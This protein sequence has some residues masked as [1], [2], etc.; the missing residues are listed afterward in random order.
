MED[1]NTLEITEEKL[2][3]AIKQQFG[4]NKDFSITD[5][6]DGS[7]LIN[8]NDTKRSYYIESTGNIIDESNMIK[9]GTAEE[10]KA[11]RDDVNKGNTYEGK[12]VYLTNDIILDINEEW[13]PIGLYPSISNGVT[14]S[15]NNKPFK[16]IF[17][18]KGFEIDGIYINTTERGQGLFGF[19]EGATIKNLGIGESCNISGGTA[20]GGVAGYI[21]N[22]SRILNSYNKGNI[23][24]N[25]YVGG[26]SGYQ[27]LECKIDHCYNEGNVTSKG[28]HAAGIVNSEDGVI[29]EC[30][31]SGDISANN[32]ASGISNTNSK[33]ITKSYNV[34]NIMANTLASGICSNNTGSIEQC[35]NTGNIITDSVYASGIV[36]FNNGTIL[37]CYNIGNISGSYCVGSITGKIEDGTCRNCYNV[38]NVIADKA[39]AVNP[40]IGEYVEANIS[41]CYYLEDIIIQGNMYILDGIFEKTS[42]ELKVLTNILGNNFKSDTN[43]INNGY[44]ILSWQ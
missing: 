1:V 24:G 21:Y 37:D 9:I 36:A 14:D 28:N 8:M 2:E 29:N 39:A 40:I 44:P 26:I 38:G 33:K 7:F 31:N 34:G 41:N 35:Y 6:G 12:Y 30:Y 25:I 10:L 43:N 13:I 15:E 4:N 18:G 20:T 32:N 42:D 22:N 11:F 5:N 27:K 16:G 19:I 23:T 3:N 17:D